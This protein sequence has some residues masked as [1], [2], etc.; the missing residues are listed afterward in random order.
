MK[1]SATVAIYLVK[2]IVSVRKRKS[3]NNLLSRKFFTAT[4]RV[5]TL[6]FEDPSDE[7]KNEFEDKGYTLSKDA[8]VW[9]IEQHKE[10][11]I[12]DK[13]GYPDF[14]LKSNG[15]GH[16]ITVNGFII[17]FGA[18]FHD[19]LPIITSEEAPAPSANIKEAFEGKGY[20]LS[21]NAKVKLIE[22][23]KKWKIS[24]KKRGYS[25][26]SLESN[27]EG[28]FIALNKISYYF[29]YGK[30]VITEGFIPSHTGR[31]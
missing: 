22:A 18:D 5:S 20:T 28:S 3:N 16:P 31:F 26:F 6:E 27:G 1:R 11:R 29:L 9:G 2:A 21:N 14:S 25:D 23:H 10:W 17:I 8:Q 30:K 24:N 12:S 15:E 19:Q 7:I 4:F 13:T